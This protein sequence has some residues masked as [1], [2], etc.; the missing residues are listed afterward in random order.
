MRSGEG[1]RKDGLAGESGQRGTVRRG[2]RALPGGQG[3]AG[4]GGGAGEDIGL[5]G[6]V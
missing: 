5:Y 3:M 6:W 4:V 2:R 1:T